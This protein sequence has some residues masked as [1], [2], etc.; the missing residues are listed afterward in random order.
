[1]DSGEFSEKLQLAQQGLDKGEF[2]DAIEHAA[3]ALAHA[4]TWDEIL[5][6]RIVLIQAH[7]SLNNFDQVCCIVDD[8]TGPPLPPTFEKV[9]LM[10]GLSS[11]GGISKYQ[12]TRTLKVLTNSAESLC[13]LCFDSDMGFSEVRNVANEIADCN[14][15]L[16]IKKLKSVPVEAG[17]VG[18]IAENL[19]MNLL[20][21]FVSSY[22][23]VPIEQVAKEFEIAENDIVKKLEFLITKRSRLCEYRID[24]RNREIHRLFRTNE[25]RLA[26]I[27]F[28]RQRVSKEI[29]GDLNLF[30]WRLVTAT[31]R[32]V[33]GRDVSP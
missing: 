3:S 15:G 26:N 2:E 19:V 18:M 13:R 4:T 24:A 7:F 9:A 28:E 27:N 8:M 33:V 20:E 22:S 21:E 1:M 32:W 23:K 5:K 25:E 30:N 10:I 16:A 31:G 14:Y 17:V 6:A 29:V 11:L 12:R